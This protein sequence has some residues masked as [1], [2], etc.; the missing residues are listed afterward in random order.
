MIVSPK[1][2][3]DLLYRLNDPN[4]FANMI[5]IPDDE[6]IYEINL[7]TREIEA[8]EFLSVS[9]E[10][11]AEIIWFKMDR[12]FD[13]I[14]LY[15]A[16]CWIQFINANGEELFCAAPLTIEKSNFNEINLLTAVG[17]GDIS[18]RSVNFTVGMGGAGNVHVDIH[19]LTTVMMHIRRIQRCSEQ[20]L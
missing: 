3:S 10:H 11:N 4:L 7:N 19:F 13:N 8:P 1:E 14:D 12:F 9:S 17:N 6:R 16:T 20:C 15:N 5:Q 18:L 2:Y